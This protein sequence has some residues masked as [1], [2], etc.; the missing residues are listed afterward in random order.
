MSRTPTPPFFLLAL[1]LLLATP[2]IIAQKMPRA[3]VISVPAIT[4][5][6]CVSNLFQSNMVLQRDKPITIWG[7][8]APGETVTVSFGNKEQQATA[9]NDRNW[10]VTLPAMRANREAQTMTVR[11]KDAELSLF[12]I[13]IGDVWLLGGQSN[14]EFELAKVENGKLEIVSA[15]YPELRILTVPYAAGPA[16]QRSFPRL[17]EWSSWFGR[18]F[19]KGDWDMCTPKV[20]RE[21]SAIGYAF[22]RRVHKASKVPVGVID[23]SRGGSNVETWID[24]ARLRAMTSQPVQDKLADWDK[25]VTDWDANKDLEQRIANHHRWLARQK[26]DGKKIPEDKL[27]DPTDLRPGPIADY[28]HPGHCFAGMLAPLAGLSLKGAIFHQ[29]YN[30]TF[31]G[32]QG[33]AMYRDLLPEMIANWRAAF[34]NPT[35]PFGI[36][37]LCTDGYPQTLDNYCEKM[38]DT[39]IYIR[40]A[41]Y[42]TFVDMYKAG[43]KNIGFASTYD[44]RRRWYHPQVKIPAGERIARWALAT[45]YGFSREVQWRPPMLIKQKPSD[46][47]LTLQLD[48][49]VMDPQDG[50]I[51]GFAIAGEDRHFQPATVTF[52]ETG[53]DNRGRPRL[54]RKQLI[55]QSPLVPEPRHFRYAWGRNPIAN[56]QATN[57]LDLPFAT[58]RSDDWAMGEVP[59]GVL[60]TKVVGKLTRQQTGVI[61]RALRQDD[62]RRRVAEAE[63]V[64]KSRKQ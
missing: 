56:L 2:A 59:L 47:A 36:L 28:N 7:W 46:G 37:S 24:M 20:A 58:Q 3:D 55:L 10:R 33:V 60:D 51:T 42:Q 38:L 5:G 8:A 1:A 27:S 25:R 29:G 61:R 39:G 52:K 45:Q 23:A 13:L 11:G 50:E 63:A 30:N 17:H 64:L 21:L 53:K 57:N 12:N 35:M 41:Q 26:K 9:D 19:R 18:H 43:D 34:D 15:N 16:K 4:D 40:A 31:D 54:D 49:D 44:L 32:M 6:L 48:R 62:E 22:A 14:M